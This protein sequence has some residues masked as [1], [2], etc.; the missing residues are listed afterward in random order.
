MNRRIGKDQILRLLMAF[1]LAT[2]TLSLVFII[3]NSVSYIDYISSKQQTNAI[4]DAI[5]YMENSNITCSSEFFS[6][7]SEKLDFVAKSMSLLESQWGTNDP[8]VLQEKVLYSQLE[9]DHL[10]IILGFN[11]NCRT[12]FLPVLFFY[13]NNDNLKDRSQNVGFILDSFRQANMGRVMIY[14]FDYDLNST[15]VQHL[16]QEYRITGAPSIAIGTNWTVFT[17]DNINELSPYL[18]G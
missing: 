8:R 18:S 6:N 13:S 2:L 16:K 17:P 4:S 3:I 1:V 9:Q 5:G 11:K 14:S 12:D 15:V 7:T 10:S